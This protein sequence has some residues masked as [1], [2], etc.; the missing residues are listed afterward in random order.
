MAKSKRVI[1]KTDPVA[2]KK[3]DEQQWPV[4][5]A[6]FLLGGFLIGLA[7][8]Y[9]YGSFWLWP[10]ILAI[11][12][13]IGGAMLA[14]RFINNRVFQ[15]TLQFAIVISLFAH[16]V[17]IV[18]MVGISVFARWVDPENSLAELPQP[19]ER[20]VPEYRPNQ[21]NPTERRELEFNRP[22][23]T[24]TP[25]PRP[26]EIEPE[27]VEQEQ[28]RNEP[29]PIPTPEVQPTPKPQITKRE[30]PSETV[31]RQA[32]TASKLSRQTA[33]RAPTTSQSAETV[34]NAQTQR[35]PSPSE[36]QASNT[37]TSRQAT[38]TAVAA[39]RTRSEPE[40]TTSKPSETAKIERQTNV[41]QPKLETT[42]KPTTPQRTNP[43]AEVTP[44]TVTAADTPSA[45]TQRTETE[46]PKIDNVAATRQQTASPQITRTQV[47]PT[48]DTTSRVESAAQRRQNEAPTEP[49]VA[50][51]TPTPTQTRT[52]TTSRPSV[53]TTAE[54][55]NPSQSPTQAPS[56][57]TLTAQATSPQRT[58]QPSPT[59]Q[60]PTET[61][62]PSPTPTTRPSAT[63]ITRSTTDTPVATPS[64]TR[65]PSVTRT[66]QSPTNVP[67]ATAAATPVAANTGRAASSEVAPSA[68]SVGR[69]TPTAT[70]TASPTSANV[71]S[72]SPAAEATASPVATR[73]PRAD[74][75]TP[76]ATASNSAP[77]RTQSRTNAPS[78][79]S[80]AAD[81]VA[82][83]NPSPANAGQ[84]GAASTSVARQQTNSPAA[85]RNQASLSEPSTSD[86]VQ[87]SRASNPRA[88]NSAT[89]TLNAMADASNTPNRAQRNSVQ[90]TS[91]TNAESPAVAQSSN[92]TGDTSLQA[93]KVA[94]TRNNADSA[95]AGVGST[96]NLHRGQP[97]AVRQITTASGSAQRAEAT[98]SDA[99][100]PDYAPSENS[101]GRSVA[102]ADAP[103]STNVAAISETG[104]AQSQGDPAEVAASA[105]AAATRSSSNDAEG[106]VSADAGNVQVDTGPTRTVAEGGI[107]RA[108]G[109]GRPNVSTVADNSGSR[110]ADA[111]SRVEMSIAATV[112]EDSPAAEKGDGGGEPS[113]PE[114][115]PEATTLA[116][117]EPGAGEPITG[118]P[119][120][121]DAQGA[122]SETNT[123]DV[124]PTAIARADSAEAAPGETAGDGGDPLDDEDEEERRRRL[125]LAR[126]NAGGS[127]SIGGPELAEL[128]SA[129]SA[130][131]AGGSPT[132]AVADAGP[133]VTAADRMESGGG[134]TSAASTSATT[135]G[136]SASAAGGEQ[137][138][139][140]QVGRAE[141]SRTPDGAP[142]S[143]GG[144]ES[145]TRAATG[146]T[147]ATN[148]KAE[149][150][151]LAGGPSGGAPKGVIVQAQGTSTA[152]V[153]GGAAGEISQL[154]AGSTPGK[155]NIDSAT[156]GAVGA[157]EGIR[158]AGPAGDPGDPVAG[159]SAASGPGRTA[160]QVAF[161]G[162]TGAAE[163]IDIPGPSGRT[164]EP[165]ADFS[166]LAG[167]GEV[168]TIAR[169]APG[170]LV[171]DI[172]AVEGPGG[173][174][175][176][177]STD[178]GVQSRRASPTETIIAQAPR[179]RFPR[180]D[181]GGDLSYNT[182]VTYSQPA[183]QRGPAGEGSPGGST[184]AIPPENEEAINLGLAFLKKYQAADGSWSLKHFGSGVA[185]FDK[186]RP[187][188][189]SDSAATGLSLMAFL[190][191]GYTHTE[192]QYK[193]SVGRGL[194]F[195]IE[196]QKDDGDLYTPIE[197]GPSGSNAVWLYSHS[198]AT[199][200]LCEAY[201][202][203]Q[204]PKLREPAQKAIDFIVTS[205]HPDRGGWRYSPR[206]GSDTSV[207]GWMMMA[208]YSA[209][210]ADLDV[211]PEPFK[212]I[213]EWLEAAEVPGK[214]HLYRYNPYAPDTAEQRHGRQGTKTMTSV[215]LLMRLYLDWKRDNPNMKKGA[216]YLAQS[217]PKLVGD[218]NQNERD[219][220]Y[221]YYGTQVMLHMGG[222]YWEKW[223]G[224]L[225]P[226][227]VET[228]QKRGAF[229]GSWN[230]LT[231]VKDKWGEHA[232]RLYV[233]SMNLLSL[234]VKN[235]RLP[236]YED[237]VEE[238]IS[239]R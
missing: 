97:S 218:G 196:N 66:R 89:P 122:P 171:A 33:Q 233:T 19:V 30:T 210:H 209:R 239:P 130:T 168:G 119:T 205:Q 35:N 95:P 117:A 177:Y 36:V 87:V 73:R 37:S 132:T 179:T 192:F 157:A 175:S 39:Q 176:E 161:V 99:P 204:D 116:R 32:A 28:E 96:A 201:G 77:S 207:T 40:P 16:M 160:N 57:P 235:R 5:L 145:P 194:Q 136:P 121:A 223:N 14:L 213:E 227:L 144:T 47:E 84:P 106:P 64:P 156:V 6:L 83:T 143:G 59:V 2:E 191:A 26:E 184:G 107:G 193:D 140:V 199:I 92:A 215:A 162:P 50:Q 203:T 24:P 18:V 115:S 148:T 225:R 9:L 41:A 3:F 23:E 183:F 80:A 90:P 165:S 229:A 174:G 112:V 4:N 10:A 85:T 118:G 51:A 195:L 79:T 163:P 86:S 158:A 237:L 67:T 31:P 55:T 75:P 202:M 150:V 131:P 159:D 154:L 45:P 190:G 180:K 125:A 110:R 155:A 133:A 185:G 12:L 46:T 17:L 173:L 151:A 212:K 82:T 52:R 219:T 142:T 169:S 141:P 146:P 54:A 188:L 20:V 49:T 65:S 230:P 200:A 127:P 11:P 111:G 61:Q 172:A 101:L 113:T 1:R 74:R 206:F 102:E 226:M 29:Q 138:A 60:T 228:Q 38:E 208:L 220:Y 53:S 152:K 214:P 8:A 15:R 13:L 128:P 186:E 126:A 134:P 100:S 164:G 197:G 211:P 108:G 189:D 153:A 72:A 22:V 147:L 25:E 93:A 216:D 170:G 63:Q 178:A 68:T 232:G 221:W 238:E 88:T 43:T 167:G 105:S 81:A 222:E 103:R 236:I 21:V 129:P 139:A 114:S 181:S 48:P 187:I 42:A 34:A 62:A 7:F 217:L 78:P 149:V 120:A 124:G 137:V 69:Q 224:K 198:I 76:T 104:P 94:L 231:P 91:P 27:R 182:A 123:A 71:A 44:R 135:S 234:E 56:E 98:R 58:T 109:G 70:P 166:E